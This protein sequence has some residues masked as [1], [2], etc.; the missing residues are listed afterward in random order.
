MR[1]ILLLV[2]A[3][4]V[5]AAALAQG[6]RVPDK[7]PSKIR[8]RTGPLGDTPNHVADAYPLGVA[9]NFVPALV[10]MERLGRQSR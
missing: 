3:A 7:R 9:P 5:P 10:Y 4:A 8:N 1:H 6:Q 2:I